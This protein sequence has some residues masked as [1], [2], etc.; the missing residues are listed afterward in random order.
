[1][2]TLM[3][4][5]EAEFKNPSLSNLEQQSNRCPLKLLPSFPICRTR[6]PIMAAA[7]NMISRGGPLVCCH[8]NNSYSFQTALSKNRSRCSHSV[9]AQDRQE[10]TEPCD[11]SSIPRLKVGFALRASRAQST[12]HAVTVS[13]EEESS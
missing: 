6:V 12:V 1:M 11:S 3:P 13:S 4:L 2:P 10:L 9:F 8:I 7:R 5:Q